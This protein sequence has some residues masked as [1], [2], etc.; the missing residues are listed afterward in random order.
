M[1]AL[2]VESRTGRDGRQYRLVVR[3]DNGVQYKVAVAAETPMDAILKAFE[4]VRE[5][6]AGFEKAPDKS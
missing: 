5:L 3:A 4:Q 1:E 6:Q 2:S